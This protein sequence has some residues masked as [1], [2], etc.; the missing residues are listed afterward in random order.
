MALKSFNPVTPTLRYKTVEDFSNLD[1]N[2]L[3]PRKLRESKKRS[4][5]RDNQG[6]I[7]IWQRGGG[8]KRQQFLVDF[9][10]KK[11][12]IPGVIQ[13]IHYDPNRTARVA[14][15]N[16]VDG[17]K[18]LMLAP[19]GMKKGDKIICSKDADIKPGNALPLENIPVGTMV[20]SVEM[21]PGRGGQIARSAGVAAQVTSKE[22]GWVQVKL[23]SGEVRR[24]LGSCLAT[25]G[26]V[27]N[28]EHENLVIGSAGRSRHMGRRPHVRG[29]AMN[30][31]DHPLG[32]GEGK[33][34]GGRHPCTPWGKPTKG[35]KTRNSK[36]TDTFIITRR[37]K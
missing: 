35:Y 27:G 36:R 5:G 4:G 19:D 10:R 2:E 24:I 32:G 34:S 15:I 31:V 1:D 37:K 7:A 17:D 22:S 28:A 6:R 29:V 18:Q 16:Y 3:I 25:I 9:R 26:Q 8:A 14:L 33:S 13:S 30:P 20:H 21:K 11:I 23:P 12:G